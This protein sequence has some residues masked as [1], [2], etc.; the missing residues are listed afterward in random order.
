MERINEILK[1][2]GF[3][4]REIKVYLAIIKEGDSTALKIARTVKIDRTTIY[5][6]LEKLIERGIVSKYTKNNSQHFSA[7]TP[8]NLIL[9]FKEKYSLLEHILPE[10]QK[11]SSQKEEPMRCE[12]FQGKEGLKSILKELIERGKD[13]RVINIRKEFEEILGY[14]NDMGVLKLNE[15][16]AKE[17]A[18]IEKNANFKKLKNGKYR[19]ID[20]KFLSKVTTLLYDNKTV[21]FIWQEPYFAIKIE[22]SPFAKAQ[23]EYFSFLW[24]LAKP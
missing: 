22:N 20:K 14:F 17:I 18:I 15:F 1:E 11:I 3:E 5:D 12:L 6:I 13:Y 7:L 4:E 8:K 2:I 19:Y 23:E 24:K 21:F 9:H 10:L 16:K